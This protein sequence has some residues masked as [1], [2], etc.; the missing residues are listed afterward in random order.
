MVGSETVWDVLPAGTI[1]S[2]PGNAALEPVRATAA[3]PE[4]AARD[5]VTVAFTLVPPVTDPGEMATE[6]TC[7]APG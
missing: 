1:T 7:A 3:P 2:P 6:V 4:G 5:R